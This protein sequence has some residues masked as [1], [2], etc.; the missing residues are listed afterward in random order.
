[1]SSVSGRFKSVTY[2]HAAESSARQQ[3]QQQQ[4]QK[5]YNDSSHLAT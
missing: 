5:Q 2:R 3:Q 1:M 4:Q